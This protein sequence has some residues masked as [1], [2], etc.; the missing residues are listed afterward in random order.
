MSS[1]QIW[2]G[3]PELH[4]HSQAVA[5][6]LAAAGAEVSAR[7]PAIEVWLAEHPQE[8]PWAVTVREGSRWLAA[9][10]LSVRQRHGVAHVHSATEPGTPAALVARDEPAGR[11]LAQALTAEL[12]THHRPWAIRLGL[13]PEHDPAAGALRELLRHTHLVA[14]QAIPRLIF[15]PHSDLRDHLSR[16]TRSAIARSRN[17]LLRATG[18]Q[19][20]LTWL[21]T[22]EQA[23]A[24]LPEVLDVHRRRNRQLRGQALLDG[25]DQAR[26][27]AAMLTGHAERGRLHLLTARVDGLLAAFAVCFTG[28]ATAWVYANLV[29]PE[30]AEFSLGTV[31]NAEVVRHFH[32]KPEVSCLDWGAG[33]QRYKLS[34]GAQVV[35]TQVLESWSSWPLRIGTQLRRLQPVLT[36]P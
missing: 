33:L 3:H 16:N 21:T 28:G 34:G 6:A 29:A 8:Q 13:L 25:P 12:A 18:A 35:Q 23:R 9:A 14:G 30:W 24:V 31:A 5:A 20:E 32:A 15:G 19:P 22:P 10:V 1:T 17:R 4:A 27:F 36:T 7:W 11:L 2:R 26:Y